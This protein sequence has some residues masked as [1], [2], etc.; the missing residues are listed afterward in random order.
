[1]IMDERYSYTTVFALLEYMASKR[2]AETIF[3]THTSDS[4]S[5]LTIWDWLMDAVL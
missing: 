1:M 2:T 5:C 3:K 4:L